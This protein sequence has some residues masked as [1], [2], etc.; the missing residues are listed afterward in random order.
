M[1][2][3]FSVT[4]LA[5]SP[6]PNGGTTITYQEICL[7][8]QIFSP[9][10]LSS[11][12]LV[13]TTL[14]GHSANDFQNA[15][16]S[17][18]APLNAAVG[19]QLASLPFAS[20]ASGFVYTFSASAGV[21]VATQQSFGP[22]L[23]E[24][25]ETIGR[26]KLFIG[27]SYEYFAFGSVDGLGLRD[28]PAVFTSSLPNAGSVIQT[29]TRIDLHINQ[30][31]GVA[32]F[33]LTN[34]IDVA[35]ALPLS[36]VN[37]AV[38][39]SATILPSTFPADRNNPA[40]YNYLFAGNCSSLIAQCV[41]LSE[42]FRNTR[43]VTG[44]G[45]VTF[46]VKGTVW[47]GE[48]LAVAAAADFRAPTG[49]ADDFLG[50]GTFGFTPFAVVSY[51][52]RFSPHLNLGFQVN[53]NSILAGYIDTTNGTAVKGHLPN[54][55][56][57]TVGADWGALKH[58]TLDL[59]F[60]GQEI[61]NG[62][63]LALTQYSNPNNAGEPPTLPNIYQYRGTFAVNNL[64]AGLKWNI[65]KQLVFTGSVIYQVNNSGLRARV[66]PLAGLSYTF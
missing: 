56:F 39:T 66:V 38:T 51:A 5:Q 7:I 32:T 9:R 4:A 28:I 62:P 30:V 45:D 17:S 41:I 20:P 37:M 44:I 19:S 31:T 48:R 1:N 47:K 63:Q 11:P 46:R 8:P 50:S 15:S 36:T 40:G 22:I 58:L 42:T 27:A 29:N 64:A 21:P 61:I 60:L 16:L 18:F 6:C 25:A 23:A 24:R 35:V 43:N 26:H 14:P 3:F 10:G 2:V 49:N 59:D 57:Y 55:F 13:K 65:A 53:G 54:N 12:P 34:R 33:G 52:G